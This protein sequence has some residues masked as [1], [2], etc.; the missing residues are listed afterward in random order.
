VANSAMAR[1]DREVANSATLR[2]VG[3]RRTRRRRGE[4]EAE[5]ARRRRRGGLGGEGSVDSEERGR[6]RESSRFVEVWRSRAPLNLSCRFGSG[7]WTVEA[8]LGLVRF[9]GI[10]SGRK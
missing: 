4:G 8:A 2:R 7:S 3:R 10:Q 1:E 9:H 6:R 5:D